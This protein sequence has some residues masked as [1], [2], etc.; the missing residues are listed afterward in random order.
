M[1]AYPPVLPS[2]GQIKKYTPM[3]DRDTLSDIVQSNTSRYQ[4]NLDE[5]FAKKIPSAD[6]SPIYII[7][8]TSSL[9]RLGMHRIKDAKTVS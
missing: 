6:H 3:A 8:Y 9:R 5:Q 7:L 1:L 2:R 4:R